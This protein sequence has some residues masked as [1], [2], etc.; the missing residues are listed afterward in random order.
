[1]AGSTTMLWPLRLA[2][3]ET[4]S[5][6]SARDLLARPRTLLVAIL[7]VGVTLDAVFFSLSAGMA[8]HLAEARGPWAIPFVGAISVAAVLI[9]GEILPKAVA[10]SAARQTAL[11]T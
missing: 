10:A 2:I 11:F 4:T 7:L 8:D 3:A 1:M 5:A 9:L 6:R